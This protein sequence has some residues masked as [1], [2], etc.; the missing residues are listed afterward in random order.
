MKKL[1]FTIAAIASFTAMSA[2]TVTV[3]GVANSADTNVADHTVTVD[4]PAI[5][6]IDVHSAGTANANEEVSDITWTIAAT[7]VTEAGE[8]LDVSAI[9]SAFVRVNHT[10]V[11]STNTNS[12]Q[13]TVAIDKLIPGFNVIL[14]SGTDSANMVGDPGNLG[15]LTVVSGM[16][17]GTN[18]VVRDDIKASYTL[19]GGNAGTELK[20][21]LTENTATFGDV[22]AAAG[23]NMQATLTYT[24]SEL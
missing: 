15:A 23:A 24:I 17:V 20:Y 21:S 3:T 13:I 18:Y 11:P 2:Q 14:E 6:I 16:V 7:D 12:G 22:D 10:Y 19:Q 4:L 9:P 8:F 1:L 5:A